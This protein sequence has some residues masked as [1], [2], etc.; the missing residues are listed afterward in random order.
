MRNLLLLLGL[1][2]SVARTIH[3]ASN[4]K[5]LS[6]ETIVAGYWYE[7]IQ[8]IGISPR[9]TNGKDWVVFRNAK[10]YGAKGDGITD[11]TVAI[12]KAITTGNSTTNRSSG[13]FGSTGQP[14]VVYLPSGTYIV[15]GTIKNYIGTVLMGNPTNRPSIKAS[16]RFT[17]S[18]LLFGVDPRY[19][20]LV[21]FYYEI[22]YLIFDTTGLS[23]TSKVTLI[24]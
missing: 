2:T 23:S 10:E 1:V 15:T 22:K 11:G 6:I 20:G 7:N 9:I 24:D 18:K 14:A 16:A 3:Q 12:Q 19:T 21:A 4:N 8:H 13:K 17:G 5:M